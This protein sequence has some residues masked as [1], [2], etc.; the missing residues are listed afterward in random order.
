MKKIFMLIIMIMILIMYILNI[1]DEFGLLYKQMYIFLLFCYFIFF[2]ETI[3]V[4]KKI[5]DIFDPLFLVWLLY[6]LIFNIR[7]LYDIINGGIFSSSGKDISY[8]CYKGSLL[9]LL[10]FIFLLLGYILKRKKELC[11]IKKLNKKISKSR[12]SLIIAICIWCLSLCLILI[13]F[14]DSGYTLL[15]V[16]TI[17]MYGNANIIEKSS[18]M[19]FSVFRSCLLTSWL[20]IAL[21]SKNKILK[22]STF[23]IG[24]M[25]MLSMGGRTAALMYIFTPFVY[26][27]TS[28]N[29]LPSLKVVI[30]GI[31][32]IV[33]L[34]V[35]I[36]MTRVGV[37]TGQGFELKDITLEKIM[38]PFDHELTTYK[39]FYALVDSIPKK[40]GYTYGK[41]MIFYTLIMMIPRAL[42]S[43]KPD[44]PVYDII[45]ISIDDIA[46]KGGAIYPNI[47]E[48][49][50]EFGIIGIFFFMFIF[51]RFLKFIKE[52]RIKS[53]E[54]THALVLY[55]VLY[56]SILPILTRGFTPG[57]FFQI[58]MTCF[59]I[60][61]MFKF[62]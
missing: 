35:V 27:Y 47:G 43:E 55:S 6:Y 32:F 40:G 25:I 50:V 21:I 20:Y 19:I 12:K 49:Y 31:V 10:G 36:E 53:T 46:V 38:S 8:G 62:S 4:V 28:K 18:L 16:L 29:K 59:P 13:Y 26:F 56:M 7:P 42:W 41:G 14:F 37:R 45:K 5:K 2:L 9:F 1:S 51:G 33:V 39:I 11:L 58:L 3:I 60:F 52:L 48:Y 54:N 57:N 22:V 30:T 44:P 34:C 17:G 15:Y 24:L 61:V 23:F